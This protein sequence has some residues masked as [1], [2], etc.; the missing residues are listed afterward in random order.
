M[1]GA[2][3]GDELGWDQIMKAVGDDLSLFSHD[4][5][6]DAGERATAASTVIDKLG[7]FNPMS[8]AAI[9]CSAERRLEQWVELGQGILTHLDRRRIGLV[10]LLE[11][12]WEARSQVL[13]ELI[14]MSRW[15]QPGR[16]IDLRQG[17]LLAD[18]IHE[19]VQTLESV[20]VGPYTKH[21]FAHCVRDLEDAADL[22][23][24]FD[25]HGQ[26]LAFQ[27]GRIVDRVIRSLRLLEYHRTLEEILCAVSV[28]EK[29]GRP[30]SREDARNFLQALHEVR[31]EFSRRS[32]RKDSR[33][34]FSS[35]LGGT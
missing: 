23:E 33:P 10:M 21:A 15:W 25:E 8:R 32:S 1:F 29:I 9:I 18:R 14:E 16:V 27:A 19:C 24:R 35:M 6:K 22:L 11:K 28:A 31:A 20:V 3:E 12:A 30:I 34:R 26:K 17:R 5:L 2:D 4:L 7:R 13:R